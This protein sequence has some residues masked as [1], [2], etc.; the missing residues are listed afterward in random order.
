METAWRRYTITLLYRNTE[1]ISIHFIPVQTNLNWFALENRLGSFDARSHKIWWLWKHTLVH[2][3]KNRKPTRSDPRNSA[4]AFLQCA[5]YVF[6]AFFSW[7][8]YSY[9][10]VLVRN[11]LGGFCRTDTFRWINLWRHLHTHIFII[12]TQ[13]TRHGVE[14]WNRKNVRFT[15]LT[16]T[17]SILSIYVSYSH[18]CKPYW[19]C[20]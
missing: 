15:Y 9:W 19:T 16:R 17:Q 18:S 20:L 13:R 11:L 10:A 12:M 8:R 1:T 14:K 7:K 3:N 5:L 2:I 6:Q 4:Q